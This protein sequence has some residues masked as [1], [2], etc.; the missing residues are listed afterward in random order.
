MSLL[1]T[2]SLDPV[3]GTNRNFTLCIIAI[4]AKLHAANTVVLP[5]KD[6]IENLCI[7]DIL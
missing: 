5:I 1:Q 7:K 4:N 6:T 2:Q 3:G